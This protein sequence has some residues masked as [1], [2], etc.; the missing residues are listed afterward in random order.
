MATATETI[1]LGVADALGRDLGSVAVESVHEG[2]IIGEF[3]PGP[4]YPAVEPV[5]RE[6]SQ[7]VEDFTLSLIDEA[8]A[9][10]DRLGVTVRADASRPPVPVWDVQI[11][12]DGGF[13]CRLP[14]RPADRN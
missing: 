11:Y 3:T 13:S 12:P 7:M 14:P 8:A 2:L 9:A 4:D 6:F 1:V 10:I 5:F